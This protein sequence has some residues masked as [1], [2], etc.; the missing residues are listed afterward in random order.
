MV[1]HKLLLDQTERG[2][3]NKAGM[4]SR[5]WSFNIATNGEEANYA[6]F[7]A[8]FA[9]FV[10]FVVVVFAAGILPAS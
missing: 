5:P 7:C 9:V 6:D 8:V 2:P 10:D 3:K 1:T 4:M